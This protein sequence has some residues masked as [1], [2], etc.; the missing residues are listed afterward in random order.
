MTAFDKY[1][2]RHGAES[3]GTGTRIQD[4]KFSFGLRCP[5]TAYKLIGDIFSFKSLVPIFRSTFSASSN[6][7]RCSTYWT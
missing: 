1:V 2:L 5:G 6:V 3:A 4:S 7:G